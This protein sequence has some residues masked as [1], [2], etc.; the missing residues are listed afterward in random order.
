ML[1]HTFVCIQLKLPLIF[2]SLLEDVWL[3]LQQVI[4]TL[5]PPHPHPQYQEKMNLALNLASLKKH[6]IS[7]GKTVTILFVETISKNNAAYMESMK[8]VLSLLV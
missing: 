4:P 1:L 3:K 7:P 2:F 8:V 6:R 5:S